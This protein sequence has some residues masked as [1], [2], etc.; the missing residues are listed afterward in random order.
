MKTKLSK[1]KILFF[2][3]VFLMTV[4]IF[5]LP[6]ASVNAAG[7]AKQTRISLNK[8]T[9]TLYYNVKKEK[10]ITLKANVKGTSKAVSW[11]SS[12]TSV[13]S[14]SKKGKVTAKKAGKVTITARVNGKS[15][16]CTIIVKKKKTKTSNVREGYYSKSYKVTGYPNGVVQYNPCDSLCVL[17]VKGN[18]IKFVVSHVGVN[19]SPLYETNVITA[20]IKNNRVSSFKWNDSWGNNGTGSLSFSGKQVTVK[21][22]VTKQASI[23][24]WM[25]KSKVTL[26]YKKPVSKET[27]NAYLKR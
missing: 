11:K 6:S 9:A 2:C 23:N 24:R 8:K 12:N 15:A 17:D 21:M 22:K 19:G 13:A 27:K 4:C 5:I 26:P 10:S 14:V 7:N 3:T 18:K 16:K 1:H 20:S 25:W